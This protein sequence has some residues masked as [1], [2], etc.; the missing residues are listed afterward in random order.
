MSDKAVEVLRKDFVREDDLRTKIPASCYSIL[1]KV[2]LE[3]YVN[4]GEFRK[5]RSFMELS[6]SAY[7]EK[8]LWSL[9]WSKLNKLKERG[10]L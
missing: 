2:R 6:K 1:S 3:T 8:K 7:A 10:N 9:T 4:K 5:G